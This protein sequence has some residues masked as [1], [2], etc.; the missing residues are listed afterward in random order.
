MGEELQDDDAWDNM[1]AIWKDTLVINY[2]HPAVHYPNRVNYYALMAICDVEG[3]NMVYQSFQIMPKQE[4]AMNTQS[5]MILY[6][7]SLIIQ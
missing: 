2:Y 3:K 1:L 4:S 7:N 6:K 5:R